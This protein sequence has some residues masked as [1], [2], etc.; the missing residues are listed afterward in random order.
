MRPFRPIPLLVLSLTI[1]AGCE[2]PVLDPMQPNAA[3]LSV[4]PGDPVTAS[5][6]TRR[7]PAFRQPRE[8]EHD[9]ALVADNAFLGWYRYTAEERAWHA[10]TSDS[11]YFRDW[12]VGGEARVTAVADGDTQ[13]AEAILPNGARFVWGK[14]I[15]LETYEGSR[16]CWVGPGW[17]ECG[18]R[19]L[20]VLWY[21]QSQCQP[22]GRWTMRFFHNDEV[23]REASF[24]LLPRLDAAK[25]PVLDQLAHGDVAY[26]DR[27]AHPGSDARHDCDG[28]PGEVELTIDRLGSA[29]TSA[30]MVLAYH[31]VAVDPPTLDAW[32]TA[33]Q[34]YS[35]DLVDFFKVAEFA[36]R[37]GGRNVQF[38]GRTIGA[39]DAALSQAVCRYGPQVAPVRRETDRPKGPKWTDPS[40][41]HFVL[42][43][44]QDVD[45]T[46]WLVTDPAGGAHRR[47]DEGFGNA[48]G[49]YLQF[50]GPEYFINDDLHGL[51]FFLHSPAEL[52]VTD[53]RGRRTGR[54]FRTQTTFDEIPGAAYG[55]TRIDDLTASGVTIADPAKEFVLVRPGDG[56]YTIEVA[57]AIPTVYDLDLRAYDRTG[58][59]ARARLDS[60]AVVPGQPHT[61]RLRYVN[62]GVGD[63]PELR[64]GF[65]GGGLWSDVDEF[66]TYANPS[67]WLVV[68]P[69]GARRFSLVLTYGEATDPGTFRAKLNHLNA[70]RYFTPRPG[71]TEVVH[72]PVMRGLNILELSIRG[73]AGKH[74]K[75]DQDLFTI[76]A[77]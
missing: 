31:G 25:V 19:S 22:T 5:M 74:M 61:Y 69:A 49:G 68:V 2:G 60:V 35:G 66:L 26:A 76:I 67:Q 16:D 36:R 33:N 38:A 57:T 62:T 27:C 43:V 14:A 51:A 28:R 8:P 64:G 23:F 15:F 29:L 65:P 72:L 10:A 45:R 63:R 17:I 75:I 24:T 9:A 40:F 32:L 47:L 55:P 41:G 4:D 44:G 56:E 7:D 1:L 39:N 21:L 70:T 73:T 6:P 34:G 46:T 59:L 52:L 77:L 53:P 71:A 50:R 48:H 42:A 11:M 37:V 30:A 58:R 3:L 13:H 18:D 20:E 12:F 54:A